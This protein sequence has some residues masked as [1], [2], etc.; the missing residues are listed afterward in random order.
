MT[1]FIRVFAFVIALFIS[2]PVW[3]WDKAEISHANEIDEYY[4]KRDGEPYW[5]DEM[6]L[7]ERG[8][9]LLDRLKVSWQHGFN[10]KQYHLSPINE[11]LSHKEFGEEIGIDRA[12]DLEVFLMDAYLRYVRD[13]SGMRVSAYAKE[14]ELDPKDWLQPISAQEA[15]SYLPH[16]MEDMAVF[17]D[18]RAP[19]GYTYNK[20]KEALIALYRAPD[21]VQKPLTI[22]GLLK[23]GEMHMLVPE[24]RVR[25]NIPE[26]RVYIYDTALEKAVRKFQRENGL[27]ADGIIG[28]KTIEALNQTKKNKIKQ[29][30]ANMERLRWVSEEKPQR[31]IMVNIPSATLWALDGGQVRFEMP[32]VIGMEERPTPTFVS[33]IHGV[34]FNPTWTIPKTVK[35]KDIWPKLKENPNYISDKGIELYDGYSKDAMT[36]DPAVIEWKEITPQ[37]LHALRMVQIPG[38]HNPLGRYRI[39]MPNKYDVYLHDTNNKSGFSQYER[40]QSSGCVR[41]HDPRKVASFILESKSSW[42]EKKA[43]ELLADA[44]QH[45]VYTQENMPVYMLYY[46]MWPGGE[47]GII[48]GVDVYGRDKKLIQILEKL[49]AFPELVNNNTIMTSHVD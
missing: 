14:L 39:L 41:V 4:L 6:A 31:F 2:I 26:S 28:K 1:L 25:F 43:D 7:N 47:G 49:D 19:R 8:Q 27:E 33:R 21:E 35:E 36:L 23:P 18:A 30:I 9:A 37:Q 46:T 44:M 29:I 20:L 48:R 24:L 11:I 17:L 5:L 34:R 22:N 15:L 38:K 13:M 32:V 12:V 42:D 3:A 45:D 40:M 10:P 16:Q